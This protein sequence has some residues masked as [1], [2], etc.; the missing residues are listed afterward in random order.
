MFIF[1]FV[2]IPTTRAHRTDRTD[3]GTHA[4]TSLD[5]VGGRARGSARARRRVVAYADRPASGAR[6]TATHS[7]ALRQRR[8]RPCQTVASTQRAHTSATSVVARRLRKYNFK[9]IKKNLHVFF[10]FFFPCSDSVAGRFIVF[11]FFLRLVFSPPA[12]QTPPFFREKQTPPCPR[13]PL[14][15]RPS[16]AQK[17][18]NIID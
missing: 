17:I 12:C 1:F 8:S 5:R 3:R 13:E 9:T 2:P 18:L 14:I 15:A 6:R 11:Y 10:F 16:A 4:P 7:R